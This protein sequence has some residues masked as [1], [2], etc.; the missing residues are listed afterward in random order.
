MDLLAEPTLVR[1]NATALPSSAMDGALRRGPMRP[2]KL[3]PVRRRIS[4]RVL[5][6][7]LRQAD[8]TALAAAT[9]WVLSR[10]HGGLLAV[11]LGEAGPE[12]LGALAAAAAL[13][14]AQTYDL[15]PRETLW[16]HLLKTAAATALGGVLAL[17][18]SAAGFVAPAEAGLF[19]LSLVSGLSV[20]HAFDWMLVR[21]WRKA[22]RLT[23][24][25]VVVGAT[26]NAQKLIEAAMASREVAVLGVFDDRASRIPPSIHGVPVLGDT[27][28]LMTHKLIPFVDR[29]VITV[30]PSAQ[31]RVREL[32]ERLKLLP[33]AV[34]LFMDMEG[35]DAQRA[36]L[37][38]LTEAP[39][40]QVSGERAEDGRETAKRAQDLVFGVLAL[41]AA[42][43]IMAATAL[44]VRLDSPG[45]IFFRQRRHGFNN[46]VI[47]VWKFRSMRHDA[48]DAT[49]ARQVSADDDRVTRVGKVIRRLSLDEL[50]QLFN[51]LGGEMSLVGPRPHAIGMK[52]DGA[53][54][55]AF[56]A[57]YA[58]RHR[59]KPGITG[60]AQIN[61]SVGALE[62]AEQVRRRV[63]LDV[64]Y[65]ERQSFWLDLYI[66]IMTLPALLG[67]KTSVR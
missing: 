47:N 36:A 22:G 55:A 23:P 18:G 53:E 63:A 59:M 1:S 12:I 26:P 48:A 6:R 27:K 21:R 40:T 31:T 50:P 4:G 49:A 64:D 51:V 29:I 34:T 37:S 46:E 60:W 16:P 19:E 11:T 8:L 30:A 54:A 43:P 62:T 42:A 67:D 25:V 10:A 2:A 13:K 17:A 14:A 28:A 3:A 58:W 32:M 52:T 7:R 57:E 15:G 65:I 39:L 35:V 41:L 44:A 24:N 20:L 5:A 66:L 45:P 33:N 38:R 9:A 56:V 61:G